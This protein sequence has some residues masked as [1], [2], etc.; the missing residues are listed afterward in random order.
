VTVGV[1]EILG[2]GLRPYYP[3]TGRGGLAINVPLKRS[4]SSTTSA[5]PDEV[6][7]WYLHDNPVTP[8]VVRQLRAIP[9]RAYKDVRIRADSLNAA[10]SLARHAKFYGEYRG[11]DDEQ[12][13]LSTFI[14]LDP[15]TLVKIPLECVV[16]VDELSDGWTITLRGAFRQDGGTR[17]WEFHKAE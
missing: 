1:V 15:P 6:V 2:E 9:E 11:I 4:G 3:K 10:Y 13:K 8:V 14:T 16:D 12:E 17:R 7:E 5:T